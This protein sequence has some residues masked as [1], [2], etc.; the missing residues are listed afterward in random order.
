MTRKL[1]VAWA[2][3]ATF[4]TS[5]LIQNATADERRFTYVYESSILPVGVWELE[6]WVTNQNGREQGD[7]S[8]WDLRTE[9]EYGLT[10]RLQ[11]ALYFNWQ[12]VR[13]DGVPG[14]ESDTKFK[15]IS[16]EW[17][18]QITN[19]EL[20]PL[21]SALY[22]E[23]STDGLDFELEGKILLSK[24][25]DENLVAGI[26]AIYEA[27]WEREDNTTEKEAKLEFTAGVSY[28]LTAA[29][30]VGLES[31]YTSAYPDGVDLSGQEYQAVSVGPNIHY[32]TS[33][34]WATLTVLPQ[35]WGDGDGADGGRQL[36]HEEELEVRLL[37][38][39]FI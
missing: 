2:F 22:A 29:W 3:A 26:N 19:P 15:G 12:S 7:Y 8:R 20:D 27:E 28:K 37:F 18:Y 6:Q 4:F 31:R 23:I 33:K 14:G 25:I 11:T 13:A 30:A 34:W 36:A 38:G 1:V 24:K 35:I 21:G 16:S 5:L 17:V 32:G 9:F 10:E 39:V